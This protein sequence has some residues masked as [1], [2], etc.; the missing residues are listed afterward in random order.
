MKRS[1]KIIGIILAAVLVA[2]A[3]TFGLYAAA[4]SDSASVTITADKTSVDS[5]G[6]VNITVKITSSFYASTVSV[7]VY[8]DASKFELKNA[9]ALLGESVIVDSESPE[10]DR[11]FANSGLNRSTY[12]A[13]GFVYIAPLDASLQKFENTTAF[14]FTLQAKSGIA[15]SGYVFCNPKSVKK[16]ATPDGR[17]Y[18]GK[19]SSG[20]ATLDSLAENVENVSV[21]GTTKAITVRAADVTPSI[22]PYGSTSVDS[23]KNI[24]TVTPESANISALGNYFDIIN[25][26]FTSTGSGTKESV[27]VITTNG[28]SYSTY[29]LVVKGDVNGDGNCTIEDYSAVKQHIANGTPLDSTG[30]QYFTQAADFDSDTAV[31]AFD[32]FY[33]NKRMNSIG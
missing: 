15:G 4:N 30:E 24:I 2:T 17:L 25:G 22:N 10:Y 11:L 16:A 7:P 9:S 8:Y 5:G 14:T 19:N 6:D 1:K 31:D 28:A 23:R 21:A 20:T 26:S 18:F 27:N 3:L 32:M 13:V 29:T 12:A 33:I